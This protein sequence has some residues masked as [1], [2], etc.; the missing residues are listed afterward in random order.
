MGA[1]LVRGNE[2]V[3]QLRYVDPRPIGVAHPRKAARGRVAVLHDVEPRP[4]TARQSKGQPRGCKR[5]RLPAVGHR[6]FGRL[7]RCLAEM[8]LMTS[9][10][11]CFGSSGTLDLASARRMSVLTSPS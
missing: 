11:F 1:N 5:R 9:L 2:Y 3:V 10:R 6:P 8:L 7:D 4:R